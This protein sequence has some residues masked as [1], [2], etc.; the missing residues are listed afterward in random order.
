MG[1][2]QADEFAARF[3]AA[4]RAP[5]PDG[6][7]A[8]LSDDVTLIQP[9]SATTRG[10][11]AARSALGRLLALIP[12]LHAEVLDHWGRGDDRVVIE[13]NLIGTL[14]G[15]ELRWRLID[16]FELRDGLGRQRRSHFDPAPLVTAILTR[17]AAWLPYLRSGLW[18]R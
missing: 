4:W 18:R 11:P 9:L 6:L 15:R 17:P 12:D 1:S 2:A 7:V 8:L 5:T 14:G 10:K 13:F 3:A 16:V